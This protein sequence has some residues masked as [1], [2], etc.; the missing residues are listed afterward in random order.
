MTRSD[1]PTQAWL[2][3]VFGAV[4][5]GVVLRTLDRV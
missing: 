1:S 2:A 4:M 5:T 3:R